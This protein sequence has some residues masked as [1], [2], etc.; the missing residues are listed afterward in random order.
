M[1]GNIPNL[2]DLYVENNKLK[3]EL[4]AAKEKIKDL[5]EKL[6]ELGYGWGV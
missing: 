3:H 4:L 2:V 1:E 5:E 6:S